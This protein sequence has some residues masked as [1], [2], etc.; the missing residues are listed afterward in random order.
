MAILLRSVGVPSRNV[1]GF[2]GGTWNSFGHY[3]S[4]RQGDAHSWIEAYIDDG[5]RS[6]WFTYDPTPTGAAQLNEPHPRIYYDL[7]D[8][9]EALSQDWN[10]YVVGYDLRKQ[11]R[12]FDEVTRSYERLRSRTGVNLGPFASGRRGA[13]ISAIVLVLLSA[14]YL[15][16][17]RRRPLRDPRPKDGTRQSGDARL[18]SAVALYRALELALQHHGISRAPSVPPLRHAESLRDRSHP[19]ADEVLSLTSTYLEARFGGRALTDG[20]RREFERRV[21]DIRA[22]RPDRS[23]AA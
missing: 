14:G 17:R 2:V 21:R 13:V 19:L 16:W 12:I 5:P 11:G 8:A 6:G 23:P 9:L 10:R 18:E 7:R 3:Y 15:V 22:F 20:S 1:T 4:V